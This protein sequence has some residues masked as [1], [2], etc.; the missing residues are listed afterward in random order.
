MEFTGERFVPI[1]EL[2]NDEI[3]FEHLHRYHNALKLV[4]GKVVLDIAC[5]EGYG[6]K[7]LS[8]RANKV[9]GIDIDSASIDHAKKTY[10][11][12]NIEFIC[13]SV[14]NIPLPD[15]SVDVVV[16]YET[17]EH[18][19]EITQNDFLA[20]IKRVLKK[21]GILI[22]S[23]P[24]KANYTDRYSHKNEFHIKEFGQDEFISFLHNHFNQ[25]LSFLQGYEIV[26]AITDQ[27]P[28]AVN[29]LAVINLQNSFRP[30]SRKYVIAIC[31]DDHIEN[32]P[33][34]SVVFQVSKNYLDLMDGIVSKEAHIIE[35]GNW[36]KTLDKEIE[37]KNNI[38]NGQRQKI[39]EQT[40]SEIYFKDLLYR[41]TVTIENLSSAEKERELL[42]ERLE[43]ELIDKKRLEE[44]L[45]AWEEDMTLLKRSFSH[46]ENKGIEKDK[47]VFSQSETIAF[48]KSNIEQYAQKIQLFEQEKND[49]EHII[50]LQKEKE[51]SLYLQWDSLYTQWDNLNKRLIEIYNSEGWKVLSIYYKIKGKLIPEN[52]KR[53]QYLKKAFN[54]LR[55][56]KEENPVTLTHSN[57]THSARQQE[58]E[59][60]APNYDIIEFKAFQVPVVSIIIPVFNGW[61]MTYKCLKSIY[62]NTISTEYEVIIADDGAT[63]ETKNI[64]D[65]IK[66]ITVIRNN[67]NLG[68]LNNCNNASRS[69][70]GKF[71]LFLNND[72]EVK[73]VWLSSLVELMEKDK[74]IGMTGSKFIYPDGRL[75]EAGGIIWKDASAWNFGNKQA[76]DLSEFNYVKEV[77]YISGA[78]ILIRTDLWKDIG[79]F[80]DRYAPAYCEDSDLAFEVRRRGFKVVYQPLSEIVHYEGY[81]HGTDEANATT[82]SYQK[83]NNEKLYEKWRD[84]LSKEHF[85]NGENVFWARDRSRYKKT[86]LVIDHYVP[87]FDRD[88]GSKTVFQYLKLFVSMNF[89]VKFMG[90][91]FFRHE[92]YTTVLQQMGIEVL[93]GSWYANNWKAWIKSHH[94]KFDFV[95]LNRPHISVKYMDFIKENTN[96]EI[97]YY[98][99]DLHFMRMLKQYEV[100]NKKEILEEAEKW[101]KIEIS[102][103]KKANL[104]LA[105]SEQEKEIIKQL[106][107]S[108][109][110]YAIKPYTFDF[111]PDPI[112]DFSNRSDILFVGGF[113][114]VPNVDA[115][116]WFVREIWPR[117]RQK[118]SGGRFI[119]VGSGVTAEIAALA[120]DNI[121]IVGFLSEADLQ[122]IYKKVKL[123]VVPLRYG[124]GVKGKTV[125]AM[126]NGL[127]L[128]ATS[129]GIE[130]LP[131]T[132][133][134]INA[135]NSSGEFAD[136]VISL[137][138]APDQQLIDLSRMET[139]YIHDHF[140]FDVVKKELLAIINTLPSDRV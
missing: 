72:T 18:I 6:T 70:N 97:L 92:P 113:T 19:D 12:N 8:E 128:V 105:P 80:D 53:Y 69:V 112:S 118:I 68:F 120:N 122:K 50:K 115:V 125:E 137:Y 23:T 133:T 111:I 9:F 101:K 136:E 127:P 126:Y 47:I 41:Q 21:G 116:M 139:E 2:M 131:G 108:T 44:R 35:L 57:I 11:E 45:N 75:Q 121:H 31:S 93:Y 71:I 94:D 104:V 54:W 58:M 130:G 106:G 28:D 52:S 110:V 99:H 38:I 135:R 5:G 14:K 123:V 25:V 27:S 87:H 100:E 16:S 83:L 59:D 17:I 62:E 30:F 40:E 1:K 109:P 103:F 73:P 46:A 84:V 96:A 32:V 33:F 42:K 138:N 134:F 7:I 119:I 4:T 13:G 82:K 65:Y 37:E 114:H 66:N 91:N 20:E 117:V 129:F 88:A 55:G 124:A 67:E 56:K 89:N 78:G 49:K 24:D 86:I 79:G 60:Q 140:Y 34:S 10:G 36:G 102:L 61:A 29:E 15:N 22:I 48:L 43:K 132:P 51:Q 95:L 85:E 107:V 64:K 77:D 3:A 74:S 81:S 76:P 26:D 63:D 90:D 98:G 39:E